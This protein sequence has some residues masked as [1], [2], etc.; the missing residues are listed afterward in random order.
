MIGTRSSRTSS[1]TGGQERRAATDEARIGELAQLVGEGVRDR[2]R[3]QARP[4]PPIETSWS[5]VFERRRGGYV[6]VSCSA[7]G[8]YGVEFDR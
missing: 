4:A 3:G 1:T 7:G 2:R 8:A 6:G 5:V